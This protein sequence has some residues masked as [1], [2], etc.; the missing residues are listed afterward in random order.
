MPHFVSF[1]LLYWFIRNQIWLGTYLSFN[2]RIN[3]YLCSNR[4]QNVQTPGLIP[5]LFSSEQRSLWKD[6]SI[7]VDSFTLIGAN[8]IHRWFSKQNV[9]IQGTFAENILTVINL[10][11]SA[12]LSPKVFDILIIYG[13][14]IT[15]Q[16]KGFAKWESLNIAW[17]S[18]KFGWFF[19]FLCCGSCGGGC[20]GC[21]G[22]CC[23]SGRDNCLS[24]IFRKNEIDIQIL[25]HS[26]SW[27]FEGHLFF[28]YFNVSRIV[29]DCRCHADSSFAHIV[30]SKNGWPLNF[31][32]KKCET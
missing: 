11:L 32:H 26:H 3:Q 15:F 6:F 16:C 25:G 30:R 7:G 17:Y 29:D 14:S 24:R 21:G 20:T 27:K 9:S 22:S 1:L 12:I 4:T 31:A 28:A 19:W 10:E 23:R 5:R 2:G 13:F 8:I 18:D